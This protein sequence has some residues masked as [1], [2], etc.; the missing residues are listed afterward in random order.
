MTVEAT[1]TALPGGYDYYCPGCDLF[2]SVSTDKAEHIKYCPVCGWETL[3]H[4][5]QT[6][7]V[8]YPFRAGRASA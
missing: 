8:E 1:H 7:E 4:D 3:V 6:F 5:K 2:I